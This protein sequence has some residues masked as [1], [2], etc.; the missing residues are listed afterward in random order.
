[1]RSNYFNRAQKATAYTI[2]QS[3]EEIGRQVSKFE[4]RDFIT[5][6]KK[7]LE[8]YAEGGMNILVKDVFGSKW[9]GRGLDKGYR[10]YDIDIISYFYGE[11][12]KI[13][14]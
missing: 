4:D 12:I 13:P 7:T 5:E 14:F 3:D 1:M 2:I 6:A 9:N 10:E 11:G 8:K